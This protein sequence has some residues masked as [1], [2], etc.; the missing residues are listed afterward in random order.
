MERFFA[1]MS[2]PLVLT[3]FFR[4]ISPKFAYLLQKSNMQVFPNIIISI[5][6]IQ[7]SNRNL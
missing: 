3:Y 5:I 1:K 6:I 2:I 7:D 4:I